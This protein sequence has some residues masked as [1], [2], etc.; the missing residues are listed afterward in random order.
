VEQK[1]DENQALLYRLSGDWNPLHADP[2]MAQAFGFEKP[3][4]HGLCTFGF[5][6]RH[7][8]GEFAPDADPRY[9]KNIS[10]RFADSV[11]PGETLV[12]EMWKESDTKIIFRTRVKERESDVITRAAVELYE[13]IP[14][15]EPKPEPKAEEADAASAEPISADVFTGIRAYFEQKAGDVKSIGKVFKFELANPASTWTLDCKEASVAQGESTKPDCTLQ[16]SD[17]DFMA[18]CAGEADPMKLFSSGALKISG[19]VMAS[20][21]LEFLQEIDPKLVM[22]AAKA[23]AGGGGADAA[24]AGGGGNPV[25]DV[26]LGIAAYID[27]N[28]AV[29]SIGKTFVFDLKDPDSSWTL[30][31]NEGR[32]RAGGGKADC[33][34]ELSQEDFMAMTAGEAD[35]MKLFST[36]K[37]KISG[38][39]MASQKL[40]FLQEIDPEEARKAVE[41]ARAA[42]KTLLGSESPDAGG[43]SD[44]VN[45]TK[46]FEGLKERLAENT[47][48][49]SEVNAVLQFNVTSPDSAWVVDMTGDGEVSEGT[50]DEPATVFTIADSDLAELAGEE[51]DVQ[52]LYMQGTLRVD[53]DVTNARKL[54]FMKQLAV[55]N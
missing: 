36:G 14:K 54:G 32:V 21:K 6:A 11:F 47:D 51:P 29:T 26:F 19:D 5:A 38:D 39:V 9:F 4:L 8:I 41:E 35:P 44:A 40:E 16:L 37:L 1:T 12:T 42:G 43:A 3:I 25:E 22:D 17:A 50:A 13:E 24:A 10:V 2:S 55:S 48:L 27:G 20:Q 49:A 34:L 7:V 53:G 18:M 15:K 33:T 23:R 30:D 52:E 31:L 46:V 45:A 28:N